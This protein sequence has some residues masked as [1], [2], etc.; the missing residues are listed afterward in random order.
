M[1]PEWDELGNSMLSNTPLPWLWGD[2]GCDED[3]VVGFGLVIGV[4]TSCM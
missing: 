4:G 3:G 2:V 1:E